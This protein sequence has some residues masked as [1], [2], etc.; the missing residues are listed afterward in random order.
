MD[1]I[2]KNYEIKASP[3][4]VFDALTNAETIKSWSGAPATMDAK[5]GTEFS[6][7]GG[8][9]TG[10]NLEMYPNKKIVQSWTEGSWEIPSI[11]IFTLVDQGDTTTVELLH[12]GVPQDSVEKITEGWEQYYMGQIQKMFAG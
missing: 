2:K 9:I 8:S 6:V 12:E 3:E 11:V 10:K 4:A 7:F 1:P 5:A